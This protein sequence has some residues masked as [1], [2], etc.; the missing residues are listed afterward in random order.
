[1]PETKLLINRLSFVNKKLSNSLFIYTINECSSSNSEYATMYLDIISRLHLTYKKKKE[2]NRL[3]LSEEELVLFLQ[4]NRFKF[5]GQY[6]LFLFLSFSPFPPPR[7]LKRA[8]LTNAPSKGTS[9]HSGRKRERSSLRPFQTFL[10]R[11][12]CS[13]QKH[14][15]P[16]GVKSE[17]ERE[18][19]RES[20]DGG[21]E[22]AAQEK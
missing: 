19:E 17:K 12:A 14:E 4:N 5:N 8:C 20:Q 16:V 1:M 6:P 18:K 10:D 3:L 22:C 9:R 15:K 11:C 21:N 2:R 13:R 7:I